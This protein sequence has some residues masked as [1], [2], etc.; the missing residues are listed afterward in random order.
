MTTDI[1]LLRFMVLSS[2]IG[3]FVFCVSY[4]VLVWKKRR[5]STTASSPMTAR[6]RGWS[7]TALVLGCMGIMTT[8]V[9]REAVQAEGMLNGDGLHVVRADS[10]MRVLQLAEEGPIKEGDV[11]ARFSSTDIQEAIEQAEL[12]KEQFAIQKERLALEPL[13]RN[14][15]L[16]REHDKAL[17]KRQ[18]LDSKL[19]NL[20]L[21]FFAARR[22]TRNQLIKQR[23]TLATLDATLRTVVGEKAQAV[24]KRSKANEQL[25]KE[26]Q[27]AKQQNFT[28]IDLKEREKEV[29]TLDA[30]IA[31][32]DALLRSNEEG[33]KECKASIADLEEDFK[34]QPEN[35]DKQI[36]KTKQELAALD[37]KFPEI[38]KEYYEDGKT[39][40]MR[41]DRDLSEFDNKIKQ[42]EGAIASKKSKLV[43]YAP[44]DGQVVYRHSS[45]SV[46]ANQHAVL[47][48]GPPDNLHL[49]FRLEDRQVD[50][51]KNAPAVTIE[52]AET[53]N[54]VEQRFPGNFLKATPL[55]REPGMSLVE[56]RCDAPPETVASL[57]EGKPI[58]ARFSWRPPMMNLWPFPLS[59]I[60]IG[61]GIVGLFFVNMT[62]WK[63]AWPR[64]DEDGDDE[65][66]LVT[67]APVRKEG[68]TAEAA[69]DTIPMRPEMPNVPREK[70][71]HAWEHP[72]GVRLREA[73]IRED[74]SMELLDAVELAIE[75]KKDAVINPMREAL[76]RVQSVPNHARRLLDRLNNFESDDELKVIEKRCLAQRITFL[77][78]TLGIEMPSEV[79][80]RTTAPQVAGS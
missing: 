77:L 49:Q 29:G 12:Q 57:V 14:P 58:K 13:P 80:R 21:G 65:D 75:Q 76:R 48:M 55:A 78:Y 47:V 24:A 46:A 11:L 15:N 26:R 22:E 56:L 28:T 41:R 53:A 51:L 32:Y 59:L 30:E 40:Q 60:L 74:V 34:L 72:V 64:K 18:E 68:D 17:N 52:L 36:E 19:V 54:S 63:P 16:V 66:A 27:L 38:E 25:E 9:V 23:E 42:T 5:K 43:Q 31:K 50:A 20:Q 69:A 37:A 6:I 61:L 10:T 35:L 33:Q 67:L 70:P 71:V 44:M 4:S 73:I 79:V 3:F 45:P 8:L 62:S 1:P 39:A 7:I 2:V